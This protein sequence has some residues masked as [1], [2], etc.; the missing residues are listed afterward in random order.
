MIEDPFKTDWESRY[1]EGSHHWDKDRAT[2]VLEE[3][4]RK[5]PITGR[6]LVPGCG[7]GHDA[8][9]FAQRK[10]CSVIGLDA[11]PSAIHGA[12]ERYTFLNL[13]FQ[14]GDFLSWQA[15]DGPFDI[16]FEHTLF[17]AISPRQRPAYARAV[18]TSLAVHG[19]YLAIYYLT[20]DPQ[21]GPGPPFGC[22]VEELNNLFSGDFDLQ[23]EWIPK[24]VFPGREG[25][26][27]A[28]VY[29]F[30]R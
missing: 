26:E 29:R 11:A 19:H 17:C 8:A 16:L 3:F 13:T 18:A 14:E 15:D 28:R 21:R 12:R 6:I 24:D 9:W 7:F 22:T 27:L 4:R 2:P 25:R 1:Q 5:V 23:A 10:N 20:P 30:R